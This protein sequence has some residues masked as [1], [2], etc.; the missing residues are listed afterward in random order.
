M[1]A[2]I[3]DF[4]LD[5]DAWGRL[6][7]ETQGHK[8]IGVEPVRAFPVTDPD[9]W[10]ALC[11]AEGREL[12]LIEDLQALPPALRRLIEDEVSRRSFLPVV[13]RI[14]SISAETDPSE[15]HVQTDRGS[16]RFLVKSEDDVRRIGTQRAI[17]VDSH[18]IRYFI[19]DKLALD[20]PSQHLLDRFV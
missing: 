17:I 7:L 19:P 10:I 12:F 8:Y 15:W 4:H 1:T 3:P 18:G 13:E 14:L 20:G 6:I 5:Y 11:D 9:H 16:V 2:T